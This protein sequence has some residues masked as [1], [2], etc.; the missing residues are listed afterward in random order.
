M[1]QGRARIIR[2]ATSCVRGRRGHFLQ[3]QLRLD[4][5]T[6][7]PRRN[8]RFV[9]QSNELISR[10]EVCNLFG[11]YLMSA[12]T[13]L[14]VWP[15]SRLHMPS[16]PRSFSTTTIA[17]ARQSDRRGSGRDRAR[18]YRRRPP[19]QLTWHK[20]AT[21]VRVYRVGRQ[22][23]ADQNGARASLHD[24]ESLRLHAQHLD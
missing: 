21:H 14:I 15:P 5:L 22:P 1:D 7:E 4:F 24:V 11:I 13:I 23:F 2:R 17:R 10:D 18:V 6:Q 9:R 19:V 8:A 16:L 3:R 20:R 12:R